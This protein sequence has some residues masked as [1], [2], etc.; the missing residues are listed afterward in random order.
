MIQ[1]IYR[2]LILMA[3]S[4]LWLGWVIKHSEPDSNVGLRYIRQAE[5]IDGGLWHDGL[6]SGIDH[7]LHPLGIAAVHR[8]LG[9]A[10]PTSWQRAAL[11]LCFAS[12]VLLVV[13]V[14]LLALELFGGRAAWLAALLVI[15][16][17]N[18]GSVVVDVLSE[19]TFL[20]FWTFGLWGSVRFLREGRFL[21]LPL[22]IGFGALAYLTRPE[23]LL[24]P[25]ALMATLLILPMFPATRINWP[26]RWGAI[27]FVLAG[28]VFLVGPYIALKGGVGTKPGIARVLGLA[29]RS[30][31]LALER[32]TPLQ[33]EQT[34]FETY[35]IASIRMLEAFQSAVTP[36]APSLRT[37]RPGPG[38]VAAGPFA[39]LAV[40]GNG[41]DRLGGGD[42][43]APR[44]GG[45][46]LSPARSGPRHDPD[47]GGRLCFRL[48]N[49]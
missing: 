25:V 14:Y 16:N 4:T 32:E 20:L 44:H 17:S 41:A 39:G 8:I 49:G 19:S 35:R 21:W 24:L 7:P 15:L 23:G 29:P 28:L 38:A 1:H 33:P 12:V 47:A 48:V 37:P 26:R 11:V 30:Q 27:A 40:P 3:G 2:I 43:A 46:L 42:G 22:A 34:T 5:Q 10:G 31:P 45:L 36:A 13:P 18:V 6:V 9:G